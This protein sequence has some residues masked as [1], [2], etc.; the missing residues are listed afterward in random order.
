MGLYLIYLLSAQRYY[1][2][3]ILN[4]V[5]DLPHHEILRCAQNDK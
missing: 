2:P 4:E 3:V 5:K 1:I